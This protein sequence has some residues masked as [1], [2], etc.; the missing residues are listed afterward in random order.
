[1]NEYITSSVTS[2]DPSQIFDDGFELSDQNIIPSS[3]FTGSFTQGENLVEF[4]I[5]DASVNNVY[6]NYNF[7]GWTISN[8]NT[9][10]QELGATDTIVLTPD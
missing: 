7:E 3:N 4:Y 10:T 9:D 8:Q 2:I 5:Y 1:M 6:S